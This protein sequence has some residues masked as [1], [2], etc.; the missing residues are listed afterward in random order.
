MADRTTWSIGNSLR[1]RFRH[2]SG[3]PIEYDTRG[4]FEVVDTIN[5]IDVGSLAD[6][7]LRAR[8]LAL[9][10]RARD[11]ASLDDM[12]PEVFAVA[13]EASARL[14]GMRPFDV[15]L[16]AGVALHRGR[17]AQLA[18]GEGKTLVAVAP[19]IL[20]ALAGTRVHIFTANDYLARRD[21]EWMGPLYSFFGMRAAYVIE[22]LTAEA[23][24]DA[25]DANVTYVTAKEAGFDF[26]RDH[27]AT[28]RSDVVHRG[29]AM[30]I[31]DEADFI[32]IDEARVPLVIA[33]PAPAMPVDHQML[34]ALVRRLRPG[35]D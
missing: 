10:D 19:A 16:A 2:A 12:L 23:R 33:G 13:R 4:Y 7:E 26:L 1:E 9:R 24:R 14:L 27:T 25:Y 15:Q 5:G 6:D 8:A 28:S 35:V 21:A 34:A 3:A 20:H 30:A 32:L 11:V 29:H 17:L 22:G 31:V 18:T